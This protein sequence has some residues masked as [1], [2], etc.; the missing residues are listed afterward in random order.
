MC[1]ATRLAAR[2]RRI[3]RRSPTS[4]PAKGSLPDAQDRGL[5]SADE[6]DHL[7]DIERVDAAG[8]RLRVALNDLALVIHLAQAPLGVDL[9]ARHDHDVLDALAAAGLDVETEP[10]HF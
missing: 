9:R 4:S 10:Y 2:A 7:F 5:A 1:S 6:T 8:H 3:I